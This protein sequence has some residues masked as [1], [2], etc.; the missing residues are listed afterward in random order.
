MNDE[1]DNTIPDYVAT[2][3]DLNLLSDVNVNVDINVCITEDE[4]MK[5]VKSLKRNKSTGDDAIANEY[6][7]TT[8]DVMM[9]LYTALFN[10]IFDTG[11][12]PSC[13]LVGNIVPIYKN[14]GDTNDPKNYRPITILSCLGKLFTS[15]LNNRLNDYADSVQLI[16]ENQAGF[17]KQYSTMDHIFTLHS[18]IELFKNTRKKLYCAFIDFEKAFDSVWRL[19]L[20]NKILKSN[21]NGKCF[22][23]IVNMYNGIKARIKANNCFSECFPCKRGVRQGENLSPF[24]FSLFLNDLEE[25]LISNGANGLHSISSKY[26]NEFNMYLNLF[27]LLYADDT[28]LMSETAEDLQKQ[29]DIFYNYSCYWHLK[30]N[31]EKTKI[32]VFGR[33]RKLQNV[34]F[35]YDG[36]DV[37][38]VDTF[39]YLGVSFSKTGSFNHHV[40]QSYDKAMKA[41]YSVITKCRKHNLSIDCQLDLFD[42]VVKPILL[43]GCEVWGFSN[44]SLIEKLHLKFCKHILNLNNSTPN[45]MVYGELGRFPLVINVKV[46]MITFWANM[47]YSN[48]LSTCIYALLYKQNSQW[49]KFVKS[50]LDECGMSYVWQNQ[51]FCNFSWLKNRVFHSLLDQFTQSWRSNVFTSPKGINYR[52]FKEDLKLENYLLKLPVKKYKL[53]CRFRCSNFKLPIET[54]RWG[55]IPR[56]ERKCKLCNSNDIGDEFHY[57]FKCKDPVISRTRQNCLSRIFCNNPNAYKFSCL[58]NHTNIN[59]VS[60]VCKLVSVIQN[61]VQPPG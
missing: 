37:E 32:I 26:A 48:K 1:N 30:V 9:P 17:R 2:M 24:L 28:V 45:Y 29:L 33:G 11:V 4:I 54:G 38:I 10:T 39:K 40:K 50:I 57:L 53:L 56:S 51:S 42:K 22:N 6:I 8:I 20:W 7:M 21:I 15:I 46:R 19:G 58:F 41:M 27:V 5:C 14:K 12:V 31:V 25:F 36:N 55:H 43:Y 60:N 35:K 59:V 49:V 23:V 47:V 3:D 34:H 52:M 18:L 13:W 16:L 61:R 44:H